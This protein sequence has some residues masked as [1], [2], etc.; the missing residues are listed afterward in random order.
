MLWKRSIL[1]N[2]IRDENYMKMYVE[3]KWYLVNWINK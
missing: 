1:W 2:E 3:Q